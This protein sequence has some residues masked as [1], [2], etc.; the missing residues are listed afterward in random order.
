MIINKEEEL[1]EFEEFNKAWQT[2][3]IDEATGERQQSEV[4][5]KKKRKN[6]RLGK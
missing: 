4:I 3:S 2:H 6:E 1:E 5:F